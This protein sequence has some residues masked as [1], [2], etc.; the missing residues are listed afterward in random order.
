MDLRKTIQTLI[1]IELTKQNNIKCKGL[2]FPV[3]ISGDSIVAHYTP[4][5]MSQNQKLVYNII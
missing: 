4:T 5:K 1:Q 2:A 3:G